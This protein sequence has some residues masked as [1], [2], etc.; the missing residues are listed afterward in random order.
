[1]LVFLEGVVFLSSI[2]SRAHYSE[3]CADPHAENYEHPAQRGQ[4]AAVTQEMHQEGTTEP[5]SPPQSM[6]FHQ[7]L[8]SF[9]SNRHKD[10]GGKKLCQQNSLLLLL[11]PG[12][13]LFDLLF[14][15]GLKSMGIQ[16]GPPLS[17]LCYSCDGKIFS[18]FKV[19]EQYSI[20]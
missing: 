16:R 12:S 3:V 11:K 5:N 9:H 14:H 20:S 6:A 18:V 13:V 7:K 19:Q 17:T 2:F 15:T 8:T 1:M 10:T 4:Y